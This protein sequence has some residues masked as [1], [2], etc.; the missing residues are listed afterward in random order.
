MTKVK[1]GQP[2]ICHRIELKIFPY[3]LMHILTIPADIYSILLFWHPLLGSID[4]ELRD[5]L[6]L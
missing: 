6:G 1:Q 2:R 5:N 3:T 4:N